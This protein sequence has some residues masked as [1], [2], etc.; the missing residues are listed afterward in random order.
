MDNKIDKK[1]AIKKMIGAVIFILL[2]ALV[3]LLISYFFAPQKDKSITMQD[4]KPNGI[5]AEKD[6]TIDV[7]LFGDSEAY[8]AFSPIQMWRDNGFPSFVCASSSQYISLTESFVH[9]SLE[10]QSPKVIILETNAFYRKMR[11]DNA[12]ITRIENM[13]SVLHDICT[14]KGSASSTIFATET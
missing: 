13:F 7:I 14:A 2:L 6:Q 10:H 9:Q 11:S 8:T 3:L 1:L 5:L 4:V 12:F